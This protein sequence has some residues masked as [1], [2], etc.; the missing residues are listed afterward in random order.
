MPILEI[1]EKIEDDIIKNGGK[2]AFPCNICI[3]QITAHYTSPPDDLSLIRKGSLVKVDIGVQVDGY[4]A[5][6]ATSI[7]FNDVYANHVEDVKKALLKACENMKPNIK[8]SKIGKIIQQEIEER[9]L[10]PIWNLHGHK[11]AR[12]LIHAGKSIP[13]VSFLNGSKI[14]LGEAYAIEPFATSNDAAGEVTE[15]K[16]IHIY[17]YARDIPTEDEELKKILRLIKNEYRTLPF[18]LRWLVDKIPQPMLQNAISKLMSLN[19]IVGYPV[20]VEAS[21]NVVAQYEH[22]VIVT[23]EG[24]IVTT[25]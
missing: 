24:P 14:E 10:K 9:G 12:Y 1:C 18:S 19:A 15:L 4:I 5:D 17:R 22:T 6:T 23:K 11:V 25:E 21:N 3:D 7:A 20:L 13:N 2:P 16:T 8:A